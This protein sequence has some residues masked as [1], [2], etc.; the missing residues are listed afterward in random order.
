[1]EKAKRPRFGDIE[2]E[3]EELWR[4]CEDG[5]SEQEVVRKLNAWLKA[6]GLPSR[7]SRTIKLHFYAWHSAMRDIDKDQVGESVQANEEYYKFTLM[8]TTLIRT[9]RE[10]RHRRREQNA[11]LLDVEPPKHDPEPD[12]RGQ[13]SCADDPTKAVLRERHLGRLCDLAGRIRDMIHDYHPETLP[14]TQAAPDNDLMIGSHDWSL[15]PWTWA[16]LAVPDLDDE[17]LWGDDFASFRAHT[18]SSPFWSNYEKLSE[19]A[20]S[21]ETDLDQAAARLIERA[22]W[23]ADQWKKLRRAGDPWSVA[24]ART[25][26]FPDGAA[27]EKPSVSDSDTKRILHQLARD[28]YDFSS[29]FY[30]LK[31]ILQQLRDDLKPDSIE[32]CICEGECDA[33]RQGG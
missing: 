2:G 27:N 6:K 15:E 7:D 26:A 20:K 31:R 25:P 14:Y 30:A 19:E 22:P 16:S 32:R 9:H 18:Q 28:G 17:K 10:L 29:R 24:I 3:R 1:M 4:L 33:C 23:I 11:I 13:R 8:P 5:W 21:L 12:E